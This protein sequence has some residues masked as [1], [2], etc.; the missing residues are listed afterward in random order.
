[1]LTDTKLTVFYPY[2]KEIVSLL[3]KALKPIQGPTYTDEAVTPM[4]TLHCSTK[5]TAFSQELLLTVDPTS[6]FAQE[7]VR[8]TEVMRDPANSKHNKVAAVAYSKGQVSETESVHEPQ[9]SSS[10]H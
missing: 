2:F 3:P 4:W 7:A 9:P 1:M 10:P 6:V 8:C 5:E